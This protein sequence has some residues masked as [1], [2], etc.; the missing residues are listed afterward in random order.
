LLAGDLEPYFPQ[1]RVAYVGYWAQEILRCRSGSWAAS[2]PKVHLKKME[3]EMEN[4]TKMWEK[5]QTADSTNY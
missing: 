3:M 2:K 5:T 4:T 1:G